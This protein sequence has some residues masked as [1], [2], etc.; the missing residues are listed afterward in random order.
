MR[1]LNVHF[2]PSLVD[3]KELVGS[4]CVVI[5]VLRATTTIATALSAGAREV[6]PCLEIEDARRIAALLPTG[7][8]LL[9]GER[10]GKKID[11]FQLG[12]S[13]AEYK[14]EVVKDRT[15]VFT[16]TNGTR[17]LLA[18]RGA[19]LV[20]CGAFVNLS[21]LCEAIRNRS[22]IHLVCA[23]TDGQISREDVLLAGAIVDR[24]SDEG[25]FSLND[26][27]TLA[28]S[29]W[30]ELKHFD[31]V[32]LGENLK[33]SRGGRNLVEIGMG[34]DILLACARNSTPLV[35]HFSHTRLTPLDV[36]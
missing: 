5:D 26:E 7:N 6:I 27:A 24:L 11:G 15:I 17:A 30:Q 3:P 36:E 21:P 10:G 14:P 31:N 16:T 20:L 28:K 18:C 23:G 13:P 2:L 32:K 12:N 4:T 19:E 9:G 25:S 22:N 1:S 33:N 34:L 29:A 8:Y 35:P